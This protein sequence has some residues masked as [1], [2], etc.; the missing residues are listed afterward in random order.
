MTALREA[1]LRGLAP[2]L[3]VGV[4]GVQVALWACCDLSPWSGGGFGMFAS[5][6][7]GGARHLHAYA[8]Y[9]GVRVELAPD[10]VDPE[11]VLRALTFP[12]ER[13]VRRLAEALGATVDPVWGRP[14]RVEVSVFRTR[15][16]PDSL[17]PRGELVRRREVELR[18]R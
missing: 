6:D 16:D 18:A 8:L 11:L 2:G 13:R 3:L 10:A 17:T 1:W 15:F 4:A 7:A 14:H 9:E 5:T 12:D